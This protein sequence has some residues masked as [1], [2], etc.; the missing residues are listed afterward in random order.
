MLIPAALRCMSALVLGALPLAAGAEGVNL[1]VPEHYLAD[2]PSP[3]QVLPPVYRVWG[4]PI[5]GA[6]HSIVASATRTDSKLSAIIDAT[7]A[8]ANTRHAVDVSRSDAPPLCGMPSVRVAYGF[9]GG[10]TF[11]FRYTILRGRLLIASYGRPIESAADPTALAALDT[12]CGG[13][14][15]LGAPPGWIL[16][17]P[18]PPNGSAFRTPDGTSLL[19]QLV[20]PAAAGSD[21]ASEP[22]DAP[23]TVVSDR[24]EPCGAVTIHRVTVSTADGKTR[25]FAAGTVRGFRYTNAYVRPAAAAPDADALATLTSFCAETLP[26]A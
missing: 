8:F 1:T 14:H 10:L 22:Y 26:P 4:R 21:I 20:A 15:Q 7:V 13:I 18:F 3:S 12:L 5:D 11:V 23:G 2:Q 6:R 25:E 16:Q 24:R 9:T 17:T 19:A